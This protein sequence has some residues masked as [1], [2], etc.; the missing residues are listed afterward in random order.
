MSRKIS[1]DTEKLVASYVNSSGLNNFQKKQLLKELKS[2]NSL[3]LA[4][5]P[6]S[7]RFDDPPPRYVPPPPD[8][9]YHPKKS[10]SQIQ[11]ETDNYRPEVAPRR[12]GM[13]FLCLVDLFIQRMIEK[14]ISSSLLIMLKVM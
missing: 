1:K 2:T 9:R 7:S 10:K 5:H 12:A 11:K 4:V 14:N 8:Y 6:S 3:P 13:I